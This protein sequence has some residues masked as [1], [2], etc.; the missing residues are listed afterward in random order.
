VQGR[1]VV[2]TPPPPRRSPLERLLVAYARRF[3]IRRGKL[4]VIDSLWRAAVGD[5][6]TLRLASLNHGGLKMRC[7]LREM[8]HR[9]FYFFGTY[10]LSEQVI[11]CWEA[12]ATHARVIFDVG[13]N[14]GIF[15]LAALA[16]RPDATVHAFEPTPEIAA[17]LRETA[18]VNHLGRLHVHEAAVWREN[19]RAA[20]RR[21]RGDL[22]TNEGMNF[23]TATADDETAAE[24]VPT[25]CL[26]R[27]C[28]DHAID[29]IDLLKLDIQGGE[30]QALAGAARLLSR[31]SIGTIFTEL[32]WSVDSG[33]PSS[34]TESIRL[35][36]NAGYQFSE[37]SSPLRLRPSGAWMRSLSD[38]VARRESSGQAS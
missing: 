30:D 1:Q 9:Q 32:N 34:A 38:V 3:P 5:G 10:F 2:T 21:F 36:E 37:P 7:D 23:I 27:F 25:I 31:G 19:G 17:A 12:E 11:H 26:D 35:L 15:S 16:V 24:V 29:R 18:T 22:G 13:A 20:L 8:L 33:A 4:R 14:A 28:E 6:S